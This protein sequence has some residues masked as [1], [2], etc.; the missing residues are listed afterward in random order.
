MCE[1][2]FYEVSVKPEDFKAAL[3]SL[4]WKAEPDF[5]KVGNEALGRLCK[6]LRSK[7]R[8]ATI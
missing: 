1:I 7:L 3:R 8:T 5:S 2:N 4:G 6:G